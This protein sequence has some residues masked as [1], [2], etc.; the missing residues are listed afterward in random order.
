MFLFFQE[1]I[2]FSD[3]KSCFFTPAN[4]VWGGI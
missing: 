3:F 4:K 2:I 1:F